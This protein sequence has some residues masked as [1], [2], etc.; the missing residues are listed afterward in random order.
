MALLTGTG[1][2]INRYYSMADF[3]FFKMA[4]VSKSCE[5]WLP[6]R[7]GGPRCGILPNFAKIGPTFPE[8]WPIIDF[9]RWRPSAILYFKKVKMLT[10]GPVRRP[11]MRHHAKFRKDRSNRCGDMAN[12]RFFKMAAVRYLGFDLRLLGPPTKSIS[13]SLWLC[14]IWLKSAQ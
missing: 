4:A 10:S 7:F 8:I 14:K 1:L 12:F 9:S 6:V 5:F 3:R 2:C 13:W 11:A